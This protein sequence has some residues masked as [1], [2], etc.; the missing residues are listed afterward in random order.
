MALGFLVG[1]IAVCVSVL[2]GCNFILGLHVPPF[3]SSESVTTAPATVTPAEVVGM[4]QEEI[5]T[6][7]IP[8]PPNVPSDFGESVR[9]FKGGKPV[10]WRGGASTLIG[11]AS[12]LISELERHKNLTVPINVLIDG[13]SRPPHNN[14]AMLLGDFLNA[15]LHAPLSTA[16]RRDLYLAQLALPEYTDT[17]GHLFPQFPQPLAAFVHKVSGPNLFVGADGIHTRLHF[18]QANVNLGRGAIQKA[19]GPI[20]SMGNVYVQIEGR[21]DFTLFAPSDREYLYPESQD[22]LGCSHVS[23]VDIYDP[24]LEEF[25]KFTL[26]SARQEHLM[27]GD[28]LF[29]PPFWWHA[30][31]SVD[32]NWAVNWWFE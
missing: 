10:V 1:I 5:I 13:Y 31:Q 20:A 16:S 21:K 3:G 7:A 32:D 14:R 22:C 28:V 9:A 2:C 8:I 12:S 17:L 6:D 23:R 30:T 26:A 19:R 25:P 4:L 15:T 24:N 29:I 18:D 27:P 11:D